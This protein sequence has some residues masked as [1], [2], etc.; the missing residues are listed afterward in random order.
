MERS[1]SCSTASPS[2]LLSDL[3]KRQGNL[4]GHLD[5]LYVC[6]TGSVAGIT[7]LFDL[8]HIP[9]SPESYLPLLPDR[10]LLFCLFK[11]KTE[12]PQLSASA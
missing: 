7:D 1:G 6:Q 12:I 8:F 10:G 3:N 2:Y 9:P 4:K 5:G 11:E